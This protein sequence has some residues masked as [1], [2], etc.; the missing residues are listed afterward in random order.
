MPFF[1]LVLV[2]GNQ[3]VCPKRFKDEFIYTLNG[4]NLH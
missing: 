3:L 1:V 4:R 2:Y